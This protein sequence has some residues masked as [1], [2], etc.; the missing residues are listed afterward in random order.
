[1]IQQAGDADTLLLAATEDILPLLAGVPTAL[2]VG[3]VAEAGGVEHALEVVLALALRPH[4]HLAVRVDYLVA[5]RAY[6]Q[7]RPLRQEHDAVLPDG[8]WPAH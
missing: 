1:M 8:L 5:Q 7:V 6:C 4:V 2:A 3:E